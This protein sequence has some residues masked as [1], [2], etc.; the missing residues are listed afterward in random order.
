MVAYGPLPYI[1]P[2][3]P[4]PEMV[5][6][7]WPCSP[8]ASIRGTKHLIPCIVPSRF[9]VIAVYQASGSGVSRLC[10]GKPIAKWLSS[11]TC[12]APNVS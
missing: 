11:N 5:A 6:S 8:A 12:A 7:T 2:L 10:P 9:T 4:A 3:A 1:V